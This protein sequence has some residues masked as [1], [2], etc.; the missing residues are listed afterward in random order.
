MSNYDEFEEFDDPDYG[1]KP[2]RA[3]MSGCAKLTIGCGVLCAVGAVV[4][5]V[6]VAWIAANARKFGAD[7]ATAG[8][9]EALKELKLPADQQQRIFDRIDDVGE[10]FKEKEITLEEVARIFENIGKGPLI[11]AGMVLV[12]E[13]AYLDESGLDEEEK[14]AAR[15]T[16]Q[17]FTHGAVRKMIPQTKVDEVL[18]TIT[19]TKNNKGERKFRHP[20][21]DEE[22]R[23]FL[24]QA[25][26]AADEANVPEDVPKINFADEFDK[27]IDQALG[28]AAPDEAAGKNE[29][30]PEAS[31]AH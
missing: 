14:T 27:A 13:R 5:L 24:D 6:V 1:Q 3:G 23:N 9:K 8:M 2:R 19:E 21:S 4:A 10:R 7:L 28:E 12:V 17:R 15:V 20:I 30:E 29:A 31:D 16:I 22:L 11:P 18:D 25:M 26:Q